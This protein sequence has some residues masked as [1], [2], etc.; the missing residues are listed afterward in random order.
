MPTTQSA[1]LP[2]SRAC[3]IRM[4]CSVLSSAWPICSEPVTLGGGITIVNGSASGRAGRNMP[5]LSHFAYQRA[6][7]SA[8][9]KVFGSSVMP[10]L[11]ARRRVSATPSEPL[12]EPAMHLAVP[13]DR[14]LRLQDP[15]IL[16][17]KDDQPRGNAAPL[18]RVEHAER[19]AVRDPEVALA[20][21]HEHRRPPVLDEIHRIVALVIGRG[22]GL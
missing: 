12:I 8:G 18:Q 5:S 21:D 22:L 9:S 2:C 4:S 19:L 13:L 11:L 14:V 10:A 15:V 6:S 17:R 3:R 20:V 7:I 1:S 16:V